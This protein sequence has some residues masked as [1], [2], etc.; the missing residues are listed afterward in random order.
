MNRET[1]TF[2]AYEPDQML[3]LPPSMRDWLETGHLVYFVMDMVQELKLDGIYEAYDGRQGGKPPYDPTMMT[4]LLLYGYCVG[5]FSSRKIEKATYEQVPF[6]VLTADQHPDHDT[7][8]EFRRR[9][10]QELSGLFVQVLRLCQKAGMVKLGH[11]ALDG[12]KIQANASKHKAMSY[13]RM[14]KKA[15]ELEADV[16]RLMAEAE[17]TDAEEDRKHG[18]GKRGDELPEDLR[19]KETRLRKIKAAM[20]ALEEEAKG[21]PEAKAQRNFTDP[22]SRI[23]KDGATKAFV[24][25]YNCQAAVDAS[26]VIVAAEVT[27]QGNDKQQ[28]K[29]MVSAI[30]KNTHSVPGTM[31]QDNGYFSEENVQYLEKKGIVGYV[32]TGRQKHGQ[33][34][35]P[36]CRGRIPEGLT[37]RERMARKLATK[38]GRAIYAKRKEIV[39]PVFGQIKEARGFRR[40]LLRGMEAVQGEW[41][42]VCL[43]HN[44]LKLFRHEI[45]P[46]M[47]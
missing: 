21:R 17:A 40:F 39:E 26:Q 22:D 3:L 1:T 29:P 34:T 43:T 13:D 42:L 15:A 14:E 38:R 44:L 30:R 4:G 45:V 16:K 6:R 31:T 47:G 28:V 2:R 32:A 33:E 7:I 18:K 11:V 25:S 10:L 46:V 5:V 9:H 12:T 19:F 27:Q 35:P 8:S 37:I 41:S 36:C 24:Q 23:M 20:K